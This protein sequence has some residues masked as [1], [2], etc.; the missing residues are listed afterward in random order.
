MGGSTAR[1]NN[2]FVAGEILGWHVAFVPTDADDDLFKW[3]SRRDHIIDEDLFTIAGFIVGFAT[4][5]MPRCKNIGRA[6][7]IIIAVVA[8][9]VIV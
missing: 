9:V 6:V 7:R 4:G 2:R 1:L 3:R 5:I 8:I